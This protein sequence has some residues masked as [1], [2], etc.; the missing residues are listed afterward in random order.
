[1]LQNNI[2]FTS[3]FS[4]MGSQKFQ[5]RIFTPDRYKYLYSICMA[6]TRTYIMD[7]PE[8][9]INKTI[10][11]KNLLSVETLKINILIY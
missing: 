2:L 7:V 6:H 10:I 3:T 5:H 9:E 11:F 1:M 8:C 4:L